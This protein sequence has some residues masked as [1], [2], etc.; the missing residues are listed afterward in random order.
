MLASTQA[1]APY[2]VEIDGP[3]LCS[4]GRY[5][6]GEASPGTQIDGRT[7]ERM[8]AFTS[9]G[10]V[11]AGSFEFR[12]PAGAATV[13]SGSMIF[14]HAQEAFSY[15]YLE[16][17]GARRAVIALSDELM[18]EA[19]EACGRKCATFANAALPPSRAT[20]ALY[21]LVRRIARSSQPME[22]DLLDL[23]RAALMFGRDAPVPRLSAATRRCVRETARLIDAEY[24]ADL[25]LRDLA[26]ACNLS[27]FHFLRAF[28]GEIG[29][30][31]VRYLIA[32]RL[33]AAADRLIETRAPI[34]AIA[35]DVGFNDLSHFN[36]M[37]RATF[38]VSPRRWRAGEKGPGACVLPSSRRK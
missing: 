29:D 6:A 26:A 21:G 11:L 5:A 1:S 25:R 24:A 32:A 9:I 7:H 35:F 10:V 13:A 33:R 3:I 16:A 23:V 20:A 34:A 17:R 22:E 31:P 37:F 4:R 14:G 30:S 19:A 38:G 18:D 27:R 8:H 12:T 36:A 2:R 15:R 28:K